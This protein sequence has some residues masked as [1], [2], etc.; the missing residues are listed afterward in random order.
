MCGDDKCSLENFW[1]FFNDSQKLTKERYLR[2]TKQIDNTGR[3]PFDYLIEHNRLDVLEHVMKQSQ[4]FSATATQKVTGNWCLDDYFNLEHTLPDGQ[5]SLE[6]LFKLAEENP[7][8]REICEFVL[9]N[10]SVKAM[11]QPDSKGQ[12]ALHYAAKRKFLGENK[13][14]EYMTKVAGGVATSYSGDYKRATDQMDYNDQSVLRH[15]IESN[16]KK[17]L[18]K[19][20]AINCVPSRRLSA[21]YGRKQWQ[22]NDFFELDET[23][24]DELTDFEWMQD[25]AQRK[26]DEYGFIVALFTNNMTKELK[27]KLITKIE[28]KAQAKSDKVITDVPNPPTARRAPM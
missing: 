14:S 24:E 8:Y 12:N 6:H 5:T 15:L 17:G 1:N 11:Q 19:F 18:E 26:P 25:L 16:N 23:R 13:M 22:L 9:D 7:D 21:M 2:Q 4:G 28:E 10:L 3:T 20:I 27:K